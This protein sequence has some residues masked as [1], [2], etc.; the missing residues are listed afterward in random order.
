MLL[1]EKE[2]DFYVECIEEL[3]DLEEFRSMNTFIQHGKVSCLEHSLAV[4]YYSY[5][6]S[7]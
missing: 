1:K 7:K 6:L 2:I 4:A 5:I 3:M